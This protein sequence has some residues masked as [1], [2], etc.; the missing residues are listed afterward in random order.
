MKKVVVG[1][2][3]WCAEQPHEWTIGSPH[4]RAQAF[5]ETWRSQVLEC[6]APDIIHVTDSASPLKPPRHD[7]LPGVVWTSLDRN[8]GHANDIRTGKIK[9]KYSGF[10]RSVLLG[11]AYAMMCDATHYVYVEQDCLVFG[12]DFLSAAIGTSDADI[13]LG[14]PTENGLGLSGIAAPM[15][16][17][18][19]MIVRKAGLERFICQM[20]SPPHSDGEISPE[21]TMRQFLPPFDFLKVPYGRSRPIDPLSAHFY[22]QH[23]SEAELELIRPRMAAPNARRSRWPF[24]LRSR[25]S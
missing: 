18:S 6:I 19:V 22:A 4:T 8:Y 16:Q 25:R 3:W 12:R 15:I 20:L 24:H 10:T 13:F 9:T 17:Q 2:G 11:A 5:F 7:R 21:E 14:M 1:T 23:L